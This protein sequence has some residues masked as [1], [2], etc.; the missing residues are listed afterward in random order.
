MC[1]FALGGGFARGSPTR[2]T[3]VQLGASLAGK[4]S[5]EAT[6][7]SSGGSRRLL[8]PEEIGRCSIIAALWRL[9]C[10]FDR[11]ARIAI[12]AAG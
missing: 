7:T 10:G 8:P 9:R 12:D 6:S 2:R 5:F 3:G 1:V 4:P 11:A